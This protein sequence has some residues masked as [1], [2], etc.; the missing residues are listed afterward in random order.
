M[1]R[2]FSLAAYSFSHF[3]VDFCC[4]YILFSKEQSL[5]VFFLY[6]CVAF[7]LQVIVGALCDRYKSFPVGIAGCIMVMC[8][9]PLTRA[10]LASVVLS[11]V[12]N[13]FFHVGGGIDSLVYSRG[14]M[15]RSGIFVSTGALGVCFGTLCAKAGFSILLPASLMLFAIALIAVFV[16]KLPDERRQAPDAA[17]SI[18]AAAVILLAC[19]SVFIRTFSLSI[20][21]SEWKVSTFFVILAAVATFFGKAA[22]GILADIFSPRAVGTGALL[23]SAP[24]LC[25]GHI[26]PYI[27][28]VGIF[29][30]NLTMPISLCA[31]SGAMPDNPGTAFGL[32]TLALVLGT[33]PLLFYGGQYAVPLTVGL[34]A[35]S[36]VF[37]F[38]STKRRKA[39]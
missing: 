31:L 28:L 2:A 8:A 15:A 5:E 37:T 34:T 19:G 14:G 16:K 1:K 39:V 24:L 26:S 36:A 30:F 21:P 17:A 33:V 20:A 18:P 7:G 29:L 3:A 4:F 22:G 9:L 12:G 32:S 11:A 25:L 23:L 27:T 6:N 38:I 13:A 35:L 10:Y